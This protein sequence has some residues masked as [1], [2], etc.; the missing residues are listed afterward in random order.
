MKHSDTSPGIRLQKFLAERGVASRRH[1]AAMIVDGHVSVNGAL[2][3]EAGYRVVP[4]RDDIR[5]DGAVVPPVVEPARTI[6]LHKPRGYVCSTVARGTGTRTVYALLADVHERLV[7]AGRLDA[8]SEGLLLLSN[9]GDLIL[10]LTHP[11]YGHTKRYHVTVEGAVTDAV[12]ARLRSRLDID[13][14]RIQPVDIERLR[15]PAAPD[16]STTLC[17]ALREGRNRQIRR[18]CAQVGLRVR[19]LVRI[20]VG[21]VE[22]GNLPPGAWREL[23]AEELRALRGAG[24]CR[25]A[26]SPD[27]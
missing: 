9:D 5:V 17:F 23:T 18:M 6:A 24:V 22:L 11:R 19:R 4:G 16:G 8:D 7:P 21:N 14:Y 2:V 13:G 10:R 15:R 20:A 25:G 26:S 1:A 27:P 3:R 12:L